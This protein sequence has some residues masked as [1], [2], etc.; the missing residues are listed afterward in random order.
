M[1]L[2][3]VTINLFSAPAILVY[4][5]WYINK[6]WWILSKYNAISLKTDWFSIFL[7][8]I[9]YFS[10]I[11]MYKCALQPILFV[12]LL[13]VIVYISYIGTFCYF[14]IT[15]MWYPQHSLLDMMV[16]CIS[17]EY[18]SLSNEDDWIC[19]LV[20]LLCFTITSL[21]VLLL[22]VINYCFHTFVQTIWNTR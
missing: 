8:L 5:L 18:K 13:Q 19:A 21:F 2:D 6:N 11:N 20:I 3:T 14:F 4:S 15:F 1:L 12:Q 16:L 7:K 17:C 9:S 22:V 10:F